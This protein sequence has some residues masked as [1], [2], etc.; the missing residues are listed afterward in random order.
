MLSFLAPAA[1]LM[2]VDEA[3]VG[4]ICLAAAVRPASGQKLRGVYL[5]GIA[6]AAPAQPAHAPFAVF[7]RL[8]NHAQLA[9]ALPREVVGVGLIGLFTAQTA[10]AEREAVFQRAL[11][12]IPL[13]AAFTAAEVLFLSPLRRYPLSKHSPAAES[14]ALPERIFNRLRHL[15]SP[16]GISFSALSAALSQKTVT[17]VRPPSVQV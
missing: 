6:A 17:R 5:A 11:E 15:L 12:D 13:R 3:V 1:H 16:P 9:E 8:F 14:F 10:A 2:A 7:L 4:Y